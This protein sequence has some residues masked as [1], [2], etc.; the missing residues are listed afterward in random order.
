MKLE[1]VLRFY[2]TGF[3]RDFNLIKNMKHIINIR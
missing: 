1:N 3:F 2:E